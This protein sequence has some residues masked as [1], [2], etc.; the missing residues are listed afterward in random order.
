MTA[1]ELREKYEKD[2]KELQD[3]CPHEEY[4]ELPY[5][6]APGHSYGYVNVCKR[7]EKIKE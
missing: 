4:E 3:H 7:C 2:L 5:E 6:F 1:Q